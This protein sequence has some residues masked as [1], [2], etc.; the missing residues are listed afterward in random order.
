MERLCDA[1]WRGD[2]NSYGC[3]VQNGEG[4]LTLRLYG[5]K[6]RRDI[7]TTAVWCKMEKGH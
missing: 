6:W 4:T 3:V 5:V 2:I 7:N 1:L